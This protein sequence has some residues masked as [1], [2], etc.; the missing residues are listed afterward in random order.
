M[1]EARA[2]LRPGPINLRISRKFRERRQQYLRITLYR[3]PYLH[4][5]YKHG[6]PSPATAIE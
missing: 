1:T 6:L 3:P 4:G 2:V 5:R